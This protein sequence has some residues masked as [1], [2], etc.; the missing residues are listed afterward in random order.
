ML[1]K[2]FGVVEFAS[3]LFDSLKKQIQYQALAS[4]DFAELYFLLFNV[5]ELS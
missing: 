3:F 4:I 2:A 1:F 5:V